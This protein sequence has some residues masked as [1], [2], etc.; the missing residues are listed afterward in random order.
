MNRAQRRKYPKNSYHLMTREQRKEALV[1]NGIRIEDLKQSWDEGFRVGFHRTSDR[2]LHTTYAAACLAAKEV[3]GFD[4]DK[5]V[6]MVTCMD[7]HVTYTLTSDEILEQ[8]FDELGIELDFHAVEGPVSIK[9]PY[10]T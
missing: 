6:E 2:V 8:V 10:D 3:F 9:N 5:I 4:Q 7:R 1:K